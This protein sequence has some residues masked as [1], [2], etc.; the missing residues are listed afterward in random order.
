M[1]E[2]LEPTPGESCTVQISASKQL[3]VHSAP[4]WALL[5]EDESAWYS[6]GFKHML[7]PAV[8]E[9]CLPLQ[10]PYTSCV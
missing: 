9:R 6:E 7:K 4:V 5:S 10:N 3:T 1:V 2:P 8:Y